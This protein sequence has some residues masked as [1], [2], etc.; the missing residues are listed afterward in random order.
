[1][2]KKDIITGTVYDKLKIKIITI[3]GKT[4]IIS[5]DMNTNI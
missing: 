2:T 4:E 1:M 5:I 3:E